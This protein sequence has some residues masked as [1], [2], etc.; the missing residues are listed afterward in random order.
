MK[1][2]HDPISHVSPYKRIDIN[3]PGRRTIITIEDIQSGACREPCAEAYRFDHV[4][5]CWV[6][7]EN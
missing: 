2:G 5:Y 7:K 6:L 4:R 3:H 1:F